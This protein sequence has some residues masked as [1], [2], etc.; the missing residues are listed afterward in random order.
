MV[1]S[2]MPPPDFGVTLGFAVAGGTLALAC[3]TAD[4]GA[5]P[6]AGVEV[7]ADGCE[8]QA[9]ISRELSNNIDKASQLNFE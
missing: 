7:V 2:F 9:E 4:A 1:I 6:A 8:L 5:D 3:V